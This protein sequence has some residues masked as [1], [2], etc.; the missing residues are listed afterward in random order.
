ME[1]LLSEIP[2]HLVLSACLLEKRKRSRNINGSC[3]LDCSSRGGPEV[4]HLHGPSRG[5]DVVLFVEE[6][7]VEDP[8]AQDVRVLGPGVAKRWRR[9]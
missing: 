8:L 5:W 4:A 3:A 1:S 9:G 7:H 6:V 2:R